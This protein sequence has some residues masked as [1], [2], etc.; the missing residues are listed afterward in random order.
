MSRC[1]ASLAQ[2]VGAP[3]FRTWHPFQME[4]KKGAFAGLVW[5]KNSRRS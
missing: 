5:Q 3:I 1:L 4:L 2:T